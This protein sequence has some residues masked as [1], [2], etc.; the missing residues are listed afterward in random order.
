MSQVYAAAET[1]DDAT[2]TVPGA[3]FSK[4]EDTRS[5]LLLMSGLIREHG[6]PLALYSDRHP[7]FKFTGDLSEYPAGP[8]QFARAMEEPGIQQIFARSPQAKGRVERAA[9]TLQDRL[10]TELR[11]SGAATID[12]AN[13]V[14]RSFLSRFNQKFGVPAEESTPAYRPLDPSLSL[15]HVLCFKHS[16][17]VARDNT[18][19][20]NTRTLQLLPGTDRPSYAGL[21]VEIHENLEGLISVQYLGQAIATQEAPPRPGLLRAAAPRA[22]GSDEGQWGMA[23]NGRWQESLATLETG[24]VDRPRRTRKSRAKLDRQPTPRQRT[25]WKSVQE[26]KLRGLSLRAITR[27][28]GI[29]RETA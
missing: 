5:Y 6:I 9:G 20:Y 18:V 13:E 15:E 23:V 3:R 27:E 11:L 12:E 24:N 7:V 28:L 29:H 8:T 1:V 4:E 25:I 10:V 2:G 22:Q 14:L 26:A 16:R 21:Q 19:K 17:K